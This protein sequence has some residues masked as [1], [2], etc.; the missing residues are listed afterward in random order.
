VTERIGLVVDVFENRTAEVMTDKN[1]AC[2]GC[3]DTRSCKSC[4]SGGAKVV[5][6][7]RNETQAHAGDLVVVE[8]TSG[9][10]WASAAL[11]YLFPIFGLLAGAI[12]GGIH[13][14]SW[15]MDESGAALIS[16]AVGLALSLL[17]VFLFSKSAY[18]AHH[19]VPRIIRIVASERD[20]KASGLRKT[21][22]PRK[23]SCC[24]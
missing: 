2:G 15:G 22:G 8:Q 10:L 23:G 3:R 20:P 9:A 4:L 17:I 14:E 7:V 16:G 21:S 5:A 6:V 18:A 1:S 11:F 13:A 19:L 12:F 24:G